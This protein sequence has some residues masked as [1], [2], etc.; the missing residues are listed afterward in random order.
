[1][2]VRRLGLAAVAAAVLA[3]AVPQAATAGAAR[4]IGYGDSQ[5]PSN[6]LV[7][8]YVAGPGE[9][10]NLTIATTDG[11]VRLHDTAGI[12][13]GPGCSAVDAQTVT[14]VTFRGKAKLGDRNDRAQTTGN[15]HVSV[16]GGGGDDVLTSGPAGDFLH[17]GPGNDTLVGNGG[18]DTLYGYFGRDTIDAAD[19]G[20]DIVRCGTEVDRVVMDRVDQYLACERRKLKG[21]PGAVMLESLGDSEVVASDQDEDGTFDA[22]LSVMCARKTRPCAV[23]AQ[24]VFGGSVISSGTASG[25][26]LLQPR[27]SFASDQVGSP[28]YGDQDAAFAPA[29]VRVTAKQG[30]RTDHL[31]VPVVLALLL[32]GT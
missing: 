28:Q 29:A 21:R 14:C 18:G 24:L 26:Q 4:V 13:A 6:E 30:G 10:N 1:M 2:P 20:F 22:N 17:G 25:K 7:W 12:S 15:H 23:T 8:D 9:T 11:S 19:G 32:P 31:N 16:F 5:Y 3:A 27:F